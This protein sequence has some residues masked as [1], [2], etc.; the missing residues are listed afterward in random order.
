MAWLERWSHSKVHSVFQ[1]P[2]LP[3]LGPAQVQLCCCF[4]PCGIVTTLGFFCSPLE[5]VNL[6]SKLR[7]GAPLGSLSDLLKGLAPRLRNA[8]QPMGLNLTLAIPPNP[9]QGTLKIDNYAT[10]ARHQLFI[11]RLPSVG[12]QTPPVTARCRAP[13]LWPQP[14]GFGRARPLQ[15]G[16]LRFHMVP[17]PSPPRHRG[18][19]STAS[20]PSSTMPWAAPGP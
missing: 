19:C 5:R 3:G 4:R 20:Y 6:A 7:S 17:A 12:N 1:E 9:S 18:L 15:E 2:A 16:L 11:T 13:G 8:N 14:W 10:A